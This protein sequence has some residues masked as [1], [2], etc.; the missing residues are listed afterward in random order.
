MFTTAPGT[1]ARRAEAAEVV[2][3]AD[4]LMVDAEH[5][6]RALQDYSEERVRRIGFDYFR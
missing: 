6:V 1:D 4:A 5:T 3:R 2:R